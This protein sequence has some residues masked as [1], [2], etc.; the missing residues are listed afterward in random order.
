MAPAFY[1]RIVFGTSAVLFGVVGFLWHGSD[2]WQLLRP[3]WGPLGTFVAWCLSLAQLGGGL[4]VLSSGT[5]RPGSIVLGVVFALFCL[6]GIPAIVA[7]PTVYVGYGNFFEHFCVVCGALAVY[8]STEMNPSK[9]AVLT[10]AARLGL[11]FCAVSFTLAQVVY[12][13]FTASLVPAWI[14][15]NQTFWAIVTTVAFALAALAILINVRA[16]PAMRL[17]ALMI[18]LFGLLV[19]VPHVVAQPGALANWSELAINYL[20][21]GASWV[22]SELNPPRTA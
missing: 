18:A 22:V 17:M 2:M 12:L 9:A 8:A 15:P 20:I 10:R 13:Q 7:A 19:W 21:A 11:G 6:A 16:R 14:P 4:A 5:A 3:L 1:G